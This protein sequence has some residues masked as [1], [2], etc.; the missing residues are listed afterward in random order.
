MPCLAKKVSLETPKLLWNCCER[1]HVS[2]V[3]LHE[4]CEHFLYQEE[5]APRRS[6]G[7][8]SSQV[9]ARNAS[10]IHVGL[11]DVLQEDSAD[12]SGQV[13]C[14]SAAVTKTR[15][16]GHTPCSRRLRCHRRVESLQPADLVLEEQM[17]HVVAVCVVV[18]V[19]RNPSLWRQREVAQPCAAT[20]T[21]RVTDPCRWSSRSRFLL[22]LPA[23]SP[24][25]SSHHPWPEEHGSWAQKR[26]NEG[27]C[28]CG[29]GG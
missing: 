23:P 2:R 17:P 13:A 6:L 18:S 7:R 21:S 1:A 10:P 27:I 29:E 5:G 9:L 20:W 15:N 12:V 24:S 26:S 16:I 22:P 8:S 25:C 28:V 4:I 19:A 3:L 14:P 11:V